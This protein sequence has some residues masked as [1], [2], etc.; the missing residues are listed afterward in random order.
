MNIIYLENLAIF[1]LQ[2]ILKL[3]YKYYL[4]FYCLLSVI[5][6]YILE[7]FFHSLTNK[8]LR[9]RVLFHSFY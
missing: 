5:I 7:N 9:N 1:S 3:V 8:F 2:V 4:V 6:Y